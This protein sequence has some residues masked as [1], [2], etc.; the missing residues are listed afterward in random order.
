MGCFV[1]PVL[2]NLSLHSLDVSVCF[3]L[4]CFYFYLTSLSQICIVNV[5]RTLTPVISMLTDFLIFFPT[6]DLFFYMRLHNS[7]VMIYSYS[8]RRNLFS[9]LS[10]H[11]LLSAAYQL[12]A[13]FKIRLRIYVIF[14]AY[15]L[16]ICVI[17]GGVL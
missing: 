2:F 7:P 17:G 16:L 5:L 12:D 11:Y 13:L 6:F 10:I 14:F 8:R 4:L 3:S 9:V 15:F 1:S